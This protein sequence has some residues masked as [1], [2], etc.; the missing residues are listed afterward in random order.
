MRSVFRRGCGGFTL[1]ELLVVISIVAVLVGLLLP[2]LAGARASAMHAV[3]LSR[4]RSLGQAVHLYADDS[5]DEL[6]SS[7]HAAGFGS[8]DPVGARLSSWSL[9]LLPYLG[10]SGF[11]RAD[12]LDQARLAGR[13]DD[14]RVSVESLYRCPR[15]PRADDPPAT[16]AGQYDGSMGFNVYFVLT[17]GE[18]DPLGGA[19]G[20]PSGRA[21]RRRDLAPRPSGTVA[22]GEISEGAAGNTMVDHFMAHF[23]TQYSAPTDRV[24]KTRHGRS[25]GGSAASGRASYLML[26]GR[27]VELEIVETFD[28][29]AGIDDW[30][31]GTAR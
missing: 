14:W 6:P 17:P 26:D 28:P 30:N 3:C 4:F 31:P 12:L 27:A 7:D 24:A 9:A 1:V 21:W 11:E 18:L 25:G 22:F 5:A 16:L 20:D 13:A 19:A 8:P 2:A 10:A 23:W 29:G 15:D